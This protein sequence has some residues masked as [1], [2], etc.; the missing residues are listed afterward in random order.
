MDTVVTAERDPLGKAW[1]VAPCGCRA[2]LPGRRS[3]NIRVI[4]RYPYQYGRK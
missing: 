3:D 4:M 2:L 1:V